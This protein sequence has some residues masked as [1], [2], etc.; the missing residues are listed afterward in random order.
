MSAQMNIIGCLQCSAYV[1]GEKETLSAKP[2][3]YQS[4]NHL[5][6][7]VLFFLVRK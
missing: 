5:M 3:Q 7:N 4:I 6:D 2:E 1:Q